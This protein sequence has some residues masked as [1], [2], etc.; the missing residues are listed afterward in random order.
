[1]FS[2]IKTYIILLAVAALFPGIVLIAD[3]TEPPPNHDG[4]RD[5]GPVE[6]PPMRDQ[7]FRD[8]QRS[9]EGQRFEGDQDAGGPRMLLKRYLMQLEQQDP[10]R[11]QELLQLREH[12]PE[13]FQREIIQGMRESGFAEEGRRPR[14]ERMQGRRQEGRD[15]R[16][17]RG[18]QERAGR[19]GP[20]GQGDQGAQGSRD[21]QGRGFHMIERLARENPEEFNRLR[22]LREENPKAFRQEIQKLIQQ[23]MQ[24]GNGNRDGI[25]SLIQSYHQEQDE[26][27][28]A[29]LKKQIQQDLT[30]RFD[31]NL[32][33]QQNRVREMESRLEGLKAR[34]QEQAA[35]RD[36]YLQQQLEHHLTPVQ[37]PQ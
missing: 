9:R 31:Q 21:G 20:N 26:A 12:D 25:R 30:N 18:Q 37:P 7:G 6:F 16:G 14:Q 17:G 34:L 15:A 8:G 33:N 5:G 27:A 29:E 3:S 13:A 24:G 22:Q 28:K 2:T 11:F 10:Q 36:H 4:M 19:R 35:N 1:M 23:R 32:E